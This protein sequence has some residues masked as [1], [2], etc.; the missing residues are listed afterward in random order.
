MEIKKEHKKIFFIIL[1][2]V[3]FSYSLIYI[4][5]QTTQFPNSNT[6]NADQKDI[7]E[8]IGLDKGFLIIN[9][10]VEH[11][12]TQE[13]NLKLNINQGGEVILGGE[14]I[15]LKE[16]IGNIGRSEIVIDKKGN[17]FSAEFITGKNG[18]K[19]PLGRATEVDLSQ[20][21]V[22]KII[23]NQ[24]GKKLV[25]MILPEGGKINEP[26][27]SKNSE[28]EED[29]EFRWIGNGKSLNWIDSFGNS[30][31]VNGGLTW[32]K[33][34]GFHL[35]EGRR[36]TID[37]I[38]IFS[39]DSNGNNFPVQIFSDGN[40]HPEA[41]GSYASFGKEKL[42]TGSNNQD[43]GPILRLQSGNKYGVD[44]DKQTGRFVMQ[45][46]PGGR[47]SLTNRASYGL[48]PELQLIEK[49][50][51]VNNGEIGF[52]SD[53]NRFYRPENIEKYKGYTS[54]PID[55]NPIRD[56]S[57]SGSLLSQ[58]KV[59]RINNKNGFQEVPRNHNQ[60]LDDNSRVNGNIPNLPSLSNPP[61]NP[62]QNQ[63]QNNQPPKPQLEPTQTQPDNIPPNYHAPL[64]PKI[65]KKLSYETSSSNIRIDKNIWDK[66][67]KG[68]SKQQFYNNLRNS[69]IE[70]ETTTLLPDKGIFLVHSG[71][72]NKEDIK[73]ELNSK[74]NIYIKENFG[75]DPSLKFNANDQRIIQTVLDREL[76][77]D[78]YPQHSKLFLRRDNNG[79]PSIQILIN[80]NGKYQNLGESKITNPAEI[81]VFNK[82]IKASLLDNSGGPS[83]LDR[84]Y[85]A[86]NKRN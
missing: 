85:D 27:K 76:K 6:N 29:R 82:M 19:Y 23:E 69:A 80:N 22:V 10:N 68:L 4:F 86:Y 26:N 15:N 54:S 81:E 17:I 41:L 37:G 14:K 63:N 40:A 31:T 12:I 30:H 45:A 73:K 33:N 2:L 84:L 48:P 72:I 44:V 24:D 13:G 61:Q 25:E 67:P 34:L 65:N 78:L 50:G 38:D 7:G 70:K 71:P 9:N 42:F 32:N 66:L 35:P 1:F 47:I 39:A 28:E 21:T 11:S 58:G 46:N 3:I 36:T 18:G 5:A 8:E 77:A 53:G 62:E 49:G 60:D 74:M 57:G 75:L 79:N 59:L 55:I 56:N 52:S 43:P 83:D 20:D 51:I 16:T 64:Q